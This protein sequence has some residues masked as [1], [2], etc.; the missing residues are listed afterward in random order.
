MEKNDILF[1]QLNDLATETIENGMCHFFHTQMNWK[2]DVLDELLEQNE[3]MLLEYHHIMCHQLVKEISENN[4]VEYFGIEGTPEFCK[5][6]ELCAC[7]RLLEE[8]GFQH[9]RYEEDGVCVGI[10]F[11][12]WTPGGVDMIYLID[13]RHKDMTEKAWWR[14]EIYEIYDNFDV[15]EE[16]DTHR[17]DEKYR[18]N[19]TIRQ[20]LEDFE[21]FEEKLKKLYD[22]A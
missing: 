12:D 19:F 2:E 15:D 16:I 13:G 1:E 22:A 7:E 20:S 8:H 9:D 5:E 10:E 6:Q 4:L 14:S 3:D 18:N 17:Q 11:E 21:R